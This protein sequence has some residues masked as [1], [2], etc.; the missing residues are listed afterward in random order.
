MRFYITLFILFLCFSIQAQTIS[1]CSWNLKDLGKSKDEI[2]IEFIAETLRNFD[3]IAIQEVVAGFGGPQAVARLADALNRKGANWDYVISMPTSS[4]SAYKTERYAYIWKTQKLRKVGEAWLEKKYHKEIDREPYYIRLEQNGKI[5]TL[6]NFHAIPK[7]KQPETEVKYFK[8]LPELYSKDNL[9]FCGDFNLPQKHTVFNPIKKMGYQP[10][11]I[12]QK[13][14][15][16]ISCNE[17]ECL[18]SELDNI[19]YNSLKIEQIESGVI[20]FYYKFKDFSLARLVSDHVPVFL[21][22]RIK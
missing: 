6:V 12:N 7:S 21:E 22:F 19:F 20:H 11:L 4:I 10:S 16:K 2:E 5:F 8:F 18:A 17:G 15:L 1:L 14:S 3:V 9:I 13:T